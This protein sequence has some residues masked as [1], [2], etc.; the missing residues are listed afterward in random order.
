LLGKQV[1]IF[2]QSVVY[3]LSYTD[4]LINIPK[5]YILAI[6]ALI[7]TA[8]MII[9][10]FKKKLESVVT[11]ILIYIA[12]IIVGQGASV[13]VQNYVVSPNEF[14]KESPYLEHNLNF[15]RAAY[16]LDEDSIKVEDHPG[17]FSLDEEMEERN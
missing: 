10:L 7:A 1:N 11:P 3:G 17:N 5:S 12:F 6:V 8:W 4:Q 2:Q 15:T 16:G 13:I 9:S 14:A